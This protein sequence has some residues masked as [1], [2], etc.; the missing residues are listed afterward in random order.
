MLQLERLLVPVTLGLE[1]LA[2][3]SVLASVAI[4]PFRLV[5][6]GAGFSLVP[7]LR[8]TTSAAVRRRLVR[9]ELIPL[10]LLLAGATS[11][12]FL[13]APV[14]TTMVTA[15][16]YEIG[17]SLLIAACANGTAKVLQVIPRAILTG[18]GQ[19]RDLSNLN[20][21]GW[22]GLVASLIGAFAG[23]GWGLEG[24]VWGVTIGS[25]TGTLPAAILAHR[26]LKA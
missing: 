1:F 4:F 22:L 2:L 16:R 5:T 26:R 21:L 11:C 7:K 17:A 24:V 25:L 3:F 9:D 14:A 23:A 6:A 19:A 20:W 15:G 13:L 10:T 12:V 8:A 18:C